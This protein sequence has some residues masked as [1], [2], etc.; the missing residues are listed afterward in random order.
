M[1]RLRLLVA[2]GF[3]GWLVAGCQTAQIAKKVD[4]VAFSADLKPGHSTGPVKAESC[5]IKV[6]G[7]GPTPT[8]KEALQN[9]S[10]RYINKMEIDRQ[11]K[12][13]FVWSKDCWF[14]HG[15]GFN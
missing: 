3:S 9:V 8:M 5:G 10:V 1:M 14:V 15:E 7:Y 4:L 12:D 2:I 13:Y 11:Y 6:L